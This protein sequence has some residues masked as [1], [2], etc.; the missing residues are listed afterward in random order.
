MVDSEKDKQEDAIAREIKLLAQ[1][2]KNAVE[3]A[4]PMKVDVI[5]SAGII[6]YWPSR[7]DLG[8][9]EVEGIEIRVIKNLSERGE[10]YGWDQPLLKQVPAHLEYPVY[11]LDRYSYQREE[12][13]VFTT[14]YSLMGQVAVGIDGNIYTFNN[15]YLFASNGVG[16]KFEHVLLETAEPKTP[17]GIKSLLEKNLVAYDSSLVPRLTFAP[18]PADSRWVPLDYGDIEKVHAALYEIETGRVKQR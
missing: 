11:L 17:K 14:P 12:D 16:M 15:A 8:D 6:R 5:G 9:E 18:N 10:K 13:Q 7:D 4:D 3:Q 2:V 1:R